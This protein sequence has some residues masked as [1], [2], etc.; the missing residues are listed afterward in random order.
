MTSEYKTK[1]ETPVTIEPDK[2]HSNPSST[3]DESNLNLIES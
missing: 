1:Y 2:N 3:S